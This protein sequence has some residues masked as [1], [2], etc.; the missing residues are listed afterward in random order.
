MLANVVVSISF[1]ATAKLK[2][3]KLDVIYGQILPRLE[4]SCI[5]FKFIF[6]SSEITIAS[7][8]NFLYSL[9]RAAIISFNAVC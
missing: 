8:K 1:L 2:H 5:V 6:S 3:G 7:S 9:L 4:Y